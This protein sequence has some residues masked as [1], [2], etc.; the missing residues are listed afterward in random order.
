[1]S[2][3]VVGGASARYARVGLAIAA[4][5]VA[6][7]V[8]MT[9][10]LI[11]IGSSS[12]VAAPT[13]APRA[14]GLG[15]SQASIGKSESIDQLHQVRASIDRSLRLLDDGRR[16]EAF[17]QAR[18]GYLDCFEAV[19]APLDVVAGVQFRFSVEDA[20]ARVRG[21]INSGAPTGEV[22]DR[23]V[24]LRTLID[25]TERRLTATGV[26]AP[27]LVFGQSFTVLLREG[28]ESVLLL[29]ALLGY[30]KSS[31]QGDELRRPILYGVL[32]AV[33]AT[34]ITFFAV[35]AIF[36][37][38]PFGREVLEAIVGIAAVVVLFYVSFWLAA[39]MDRRR[40][41]E[42]LRARVWK[43]A[44]IGST[45]SLV[46]IGFT[47]VYREGFETVLFYQAML[48]FSTGLHTWVWFGVGAAAVVLAAAA[49]AIIKL[50]RILP[51]R[52]FLSVAV[53]IMMATSVALIGNAMRA[54]QESAVIDVHLL[55]GWPN[56]PIFLAQA[57]GYYPTLPSVLAQAILLLSYLTGGVYTFVIAPRR[58]GRLEL[59]SA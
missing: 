12:A 16:E 59:A 55:D 42:F 4:A 38:L 5:V 11:G 36:S 14:A 7:V 44:T 22:R 15:C 57:S 27:L 45:A 48:S 41:I 24:K 50:G 31:G 20:F 13:S 49:W 6:A 39:R 28:L 46:L 32:A 58:R 51:V 53:M 37:A 17:T 47:S 30:L 3:P 10:V 9:V 23:V 34:V 33:A 1:M 18:S 25:E 21:L 43:A 35:D 29:A 52:T 8:G 54:L 56:L 40:W 19:E 26:S 2:R